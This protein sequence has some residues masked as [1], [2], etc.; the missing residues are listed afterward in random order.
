MPVWSEVNVGGV[1]LKEL[2]PKF[3]STDDPEKWVD[4]HKDVVDR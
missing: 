2:Y 4:V 3:G 1:P